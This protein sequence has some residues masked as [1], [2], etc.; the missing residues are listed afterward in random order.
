MES[1]LPEWGLVK[2]RDDCR[3]MVGFRSSVLVTLRLDIVELTRFKDPVGQV[4]KRE[5]A[6]IVARVYVVVS[7]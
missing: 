7:T 1:K 5:G 3:D 2:G 6:V 4:E